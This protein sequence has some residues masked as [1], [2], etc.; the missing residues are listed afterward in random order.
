MTLTLA[1]IEREGEKRLKLALEELHGNYLARYGLHNPWT[2][3]VLRHDSRQLEKP[4]ICAWANDYD[5]APE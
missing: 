2:A 4:Q 5:Y 3:W 1:T